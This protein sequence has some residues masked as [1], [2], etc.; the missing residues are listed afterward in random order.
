MTSLPKAAVPAALDVH[1]ILDNY[2]THK[3]PLIHR[4]LVR[5]PRF[6]VHFTDLRDPLVFT[7]NP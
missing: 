4:W 5:H 1:L 7:R 3:T 2:A 6:H